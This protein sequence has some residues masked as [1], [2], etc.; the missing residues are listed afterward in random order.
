MYSDIGIPAPTTLEITA[1]V[2]VSGSTTL[3]NS[4]VDWTVVTGWSILSYEV[5]FYFVPRLLATNVKLQ[6][7]LSS[8]NGAT[9]S[10]ASN[11]AGC[12]NLPVQDLLLGSTYIVR[13]RG[14]T[15]FGAGPY[16]YSD[17]T[18]IVGMNEW[19]QYFLACLADYYFQ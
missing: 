9:W 13:A 10:S 6:V 14:N 3:A 4:D 15:V 7:D 2:L 1:S 18:T 8:D 17:P 12:C 5:M 19:S 11:T 16:A